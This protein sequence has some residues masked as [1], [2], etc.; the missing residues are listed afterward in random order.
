MVRDTAS[1]N[2]VRMYT[3]ERW[4]QQDE[5]LFPMQHYEGQPEFEMFNAESYNVSSESELPQLTYMSN[6]AINELA[7]Q[8]QDNTLDYS[9]Y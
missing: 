5:D 7:P 8:H 1:L 4:D 6:T 2:E 9:E 3:S